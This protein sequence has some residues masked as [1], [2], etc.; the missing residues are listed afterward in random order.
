VNTGEAR[1]KLGRTLLRETRYKEAQPE[2]LA[3]YQTLIKQT[4]PATSY[5]RAA[6]KDLAAK[7]EGLKQPQ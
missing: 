7:Y 5:I 1:L 6:R 3:A 4:S 2:T